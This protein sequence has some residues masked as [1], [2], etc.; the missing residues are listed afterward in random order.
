MYHIL[1][2]IV[3]YK[4]IDV[5]G[6][7]F[8]KKKRQSS[9]KIVVSFLVRV[10]G[11]EPVRYKHTPLKRACLPIPAHSQN[12]VVHIYMQKKIGSA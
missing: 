8:L 3:Q 5:N 4:K 9:M 2:V 1:K 7:R 11:L 6:N 10:T 12:L